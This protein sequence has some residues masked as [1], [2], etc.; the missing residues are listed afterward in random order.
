ML[1]SITCGDDSENGLKSKR[2]ASKAFILLLLLFSPTSAPLL[3]VVV[4]I[5]VA[6]GL[7]TCI[8]KKPKIKFKENAK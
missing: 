7:Q 5:E 4:A 2:A 3:L 1:K 6:L 8:S